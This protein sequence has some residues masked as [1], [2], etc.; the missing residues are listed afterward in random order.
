MPAAFDPVRAHAG[1][2]PL[3]SPGRARRLYM[4]DMRS[5]QAAPGTE[6]L[7]SG[8]A[9]ATVSKRSLI[10]FGALLIDVPPVP[11]LDLHPIRGAPATVGRIGFL[12]D[13][14]L[15]PQ[16]LSLSEEALP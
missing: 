14:A 2:R 5:E 12:R 15:E 4:Y 6:R 10:P 16:A 8:V 11:R 3:C 1:K 9:A 7:L 13:D